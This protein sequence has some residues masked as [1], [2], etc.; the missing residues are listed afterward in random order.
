MLLAYSISD[1][2]LLIPEKSD[3]NDH[4]LYRIIEMLENW[5]V[6]VYA[7]FH[8]RRNKPLIMTLHSKFV[9]F[10]FLRI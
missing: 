5:N 7:S 9:Q 8:F 10:N 1:H 4:D 6:P 3:R 2:L